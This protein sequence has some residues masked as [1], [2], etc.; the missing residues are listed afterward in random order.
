MVSDR[1]A[2]RLGSNRKPTV[3]FPLPLAP[4]VTVIHEALVAPVHA[5]PAGAVT[6]TDPVPP[7]A[8]KEALLAESV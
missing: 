8:D 7:R 1:A 4:E 2:P 6:P 3:P 5:H